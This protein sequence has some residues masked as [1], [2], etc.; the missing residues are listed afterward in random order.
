LI[1]QE[2]EIQRLHFIGIGDLLFTGILLAIS[3][4]L[5]LLLLPAQNEERMDLYRLYKAK[6]AQ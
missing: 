5:W 1:Y 3:I 6:K 4:L 2:K